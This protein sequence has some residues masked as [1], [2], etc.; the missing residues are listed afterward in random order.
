M[1]PVG[2]LVDSITATWT[3]CWHQ[4]ERGS[5]AL[6]PFPLQ[7]RKVQCQVI[8]IQTFNAYRKPLVSTCVQQLPAPQAACGALGE[9]TPRVC[10]GFAQQTGDY[11]QA[12]R[13]SKPGWIHLYRC[14]L[15]ASTFT[16]CHLLTQHLLGC[17]ALAAAGQS[18]TASHMI[19]CWRA[20]SFVADG[21]TCTS[22]KQC[23][24]GALGQ[25]WL[26]S[27]RRLPACH[28]R[29]AGSGGK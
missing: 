16:S 12:C 10:A 21:H 14:T 17:T 26:A 11:R 19:K 2:D 9:S 3:T 27:L 23:H 4:Q 25:A 18:C 8:V 13:P 29:Q 15:G 24:P 7:I 22:L 20:A 6:V 1:L 28:C 5:A